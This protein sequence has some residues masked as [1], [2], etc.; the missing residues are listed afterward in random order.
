M[1]EIKRIDQGQGIKGTHTDAEGLSET[2]KFKFDYAMSCVEE[3]RKFPADSAGRAE[4]YQEAKDFLDAALEA[5]PSDPK[6]NF[7]RGLLAAEIGDAT[8]A[9]NSIRNAVMYDPSNAPTYMTILQICSEQKNTETPGVISS[10]T[11]QIQGQIAS[12]NYDAALRTA[13]GDI[14]SSLL[15][16]AEPNLWNVQLMR[17][18]AMQLGEEKMY[19]QTL[20]LLEQKDIL[21]AQDPDYLPVGYEFTEQ[22]R[23]QMR[24]ETVE[25]EGRV[26]RSK[27]WSDLEVRHVTPIDKLAVKVGPKASSTD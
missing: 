19:V 18:A 15:R 3:A 21:N 7:S 25:S 16:D 14:N 2:I 23:E 4:H 5:R 20:G 12:G 27:I 1:T 10:T 9:V 8:T 22:M 17:V 6:F 26:A 11:L 24:L 13:H